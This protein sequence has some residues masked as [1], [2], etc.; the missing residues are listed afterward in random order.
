[1]KSLISIFL[2][3]CIAIYCS[4]TCN[5]PPPPPPPTNSLQELIIGKWKSTISQDNGGAVAYTEYFKD[6]T[7]LKTGEIFSESPKCK[8]ENVE[9]R[10][11]YFISNSSLTRN[12][13][14]IDF[15]CSP[16]KYKEEIMQIF[17]ANSIS[18]FKIISIDSNMMVI[19]SKVGR[20]IKVR[21]KN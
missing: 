13:E 6:G 12:F 10:G 11:H 1:M 8:L 21:I 4:L 20:Q 16:P 5:C 7:F 17:K 9:I 14:K 15:K 3:L 19:N 18:S 2:F